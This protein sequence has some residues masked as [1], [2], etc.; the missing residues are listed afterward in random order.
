MNIFASTYYNIIFLHNHVLHFNALVYYRGGARSST[1][2]IIFPLSKTWR[3]VSYS[4][5]QLAGVLPAALVGTTSSNLNLP[6]F[7]SPS[8]SCNAALR[9]CSY[10]T[11]QYMALHWC[12]YHGFPAAS[13]RSLSCSHI[14][15]ATPRRAVFTS[16]TQ[17]VVVR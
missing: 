2:S 6:F 14:L 10:A 15:D 4:N 8:F 16:N 13:R 1:Q 9:C 12:L 7:P 17:L 3:V 5:M 11:Q